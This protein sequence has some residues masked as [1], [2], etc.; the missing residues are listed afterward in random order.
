MFILIASTSACAG[1]ESEIGEPPSHTVE[2]TS[3][4]KSDC[5]KLAE[6]G[7]T[8]KYGRDDVRTDDVRIIDTHGGGMSVE[9]SVPMPS[10]VVTRS[11]PI[12][13]PT[14]FAGSRMWTASFNLQN[15]SGYDAVLAVRGTDVSYAMPAVSGGRSSSAC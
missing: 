9:G 2:E 15:L 3:Q 14:S 8:R 4:A 1:E 10:K 12:K 11:T 5:I 6:E 7:F 13:R